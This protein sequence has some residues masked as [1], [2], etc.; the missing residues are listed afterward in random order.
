MTKAHGGVLF[1][2]E[3]GEMDPLLQTKLL[4]VLEDKR[5]TFESSYYD[6]G[7]PNVPAYVKKLFTDG[8]PADFILIGATT[9]DP[10]EIDAAIRSRCAEVYFEPLT[11]TQIR[12]IVAQA[13]KR[14]EVKLARRIPE[15]VASYT[16][17]GRKAVQILADAQGHALYRELGEAPGAAPRGAALT[18]VE[19]DVRTVVQS[20]RLSQHSPVRGK[21]GG[22]IGAAFGLAVAHHIGSVIEIE[23][24]A[25]LAPERRKGTV[26]FNETA[27]SMAKDSVFNATSVVRAKTGVD[28]LDYAVHVN[29]VGGGNIDGPS[30]GLAVF[31]ALYS[32]IS[33]TALLQ[34]VAV[35]GEVSIAGKV[36]A[37]GGIPEKLYAARQAGMRLVLVPRENER[38]VGPGIGGLEVVPVRDVV[39]AFAALGIVRPAA[40]R[41]ARKAVR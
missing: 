20:G 4:K 34:D 7:D 22:A 32:A 30:A 17:E 15:L 39:E 27:G 37:V 2:D 11:E 18:I 31:L 41:P 24:A 21:R 38:D 35:T 14:L 36:R 9:R 8:A 3:L 33:Q 40:P 12:E 13:A 6:P 25:F 16:V 19:Q 10:A 28:P 1:I 5:F 29:V 26:R 23:A